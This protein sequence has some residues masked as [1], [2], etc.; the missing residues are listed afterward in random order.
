GKPTGRRPV[1][2]QRAL[3]R[4][5]TDDCAPV[6]TAT[7]RRSVR[8]GDVV[9]IA[10]ADWAYSTGDPLTLRV[11]KTIPDL[12]TVLAEGADWVR[13]AGVEMVAGFEVGGERRALVRVSALT[14]PDDGV[15]A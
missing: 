5:R 14:V 9:T 10:P 1:A 2:V 3:D 7:R 15:A 13:V 4:H 11:I 8:P 12:D 6:M